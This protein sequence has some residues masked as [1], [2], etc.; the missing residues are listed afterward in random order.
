LAFAL[1][2]LAVFAGLIR[3]LPDDVRPWN[4]APVGAL[5]LFAGARLRSAY[6]YAV[7]LA[8]WAASDLLIWAVKGWTP[9][10]PFVA[11]GWVLYAALGHAALRRTESPLWI[12]GT[13]FA[14]SV[15]FFLVTNFGSWV[16]QAAPYGYTLQGLIDCYTAAL[17]FY[18]GTLVSDLIFS[19]ALFGAYA[20]LTRT[21]FP[22]ERVAPRP[23]EA[24]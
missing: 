10:D 14:G 5:A 17:P 3:L 11:A 22:A 19:A 23:A 16:G 1:V 15:L 12:G 4:F 13:A 20:V 2:V 9:F 7:P 18:R 21:A 8:A 6:A 24:A